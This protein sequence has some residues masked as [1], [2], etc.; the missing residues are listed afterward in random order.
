MTQLYDH[1]KNDIKVLSNGENDEELEKL[2]AETIASI[3][4]SNNIAKM[5]EESKTGS[6]NP[7]FEEQVSNKVQ[8]IEEYLSN[9]QKIKK[10]RTETLKD[11]KEKVG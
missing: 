8:K 7:N 5:S 10:E 3:V 4:G 9:L 11:L 2:F 1:I 6:E